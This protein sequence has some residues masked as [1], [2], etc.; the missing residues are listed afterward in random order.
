MKNVRIQRFFPLISVNRISK[1][2]YHLIITFLLF[3]FH[4]AQGDQITEIRIGALTENSS[5]IGK[6]QATALEIAVGNFNNSRN[7]KFSL[8]FQDPGRE[9]L[10]AASAAEDLII[11]E[12]VKV[13]IVGMDSWAKAALVADIGTRAQIP[14]L[15]FAAPAIRP[16]LAATRWPFLIKMASNGAEQI[17]CISAL[18][19]AYNWRRVV[20][21]YED[22]SYGGDSGN[23][24]ALLSEN[25]QKV[26]SQIE[27]SLVLP[28]FSSLPNPKVFLKKKLNKLREEIQSRVFILLKL[29]SPMTIHLFGEAKEL[30]LVGTN[31]AWILSETITS[32]LDSFNDSVISSMQGAL[33]IKANYSEETPSYLKFDDQFREV[34]KSKYPEEDEFKPGI[35][36][37]RAYDS[38]NAIELA[39]KKM[40]SSHS[41]HKVRNILLSTNFNGLS[42]KIRFKDLNRTQSLRI[43]NVGRNGKRYEEIDEF[44][45]P[46][47]GF[48]KTPSPSGGANDVKANL[49]A[50]TVNWPGNST[51]DPKGWAM[52]T[53]QKP[54]KIGVPKRTS[55]EEFVEFD[56]GKIP[57]GFCIDL[58][59]EVLRNLDYN[60]PYE[61]FPHDGPYDD[62]LSKVS[63]KTYDAAV[64][65]I[66]ILAE[67]MELVEFTQAYVESGLSMVAPV[68]SYPEWMFTKPFTRTM[69][70]ATGILFIYTMI[71]VW[72]L[73]HCSNNK[74]FIGKNQIRTALWFTF[75]SLFFAHRDEQIKSNFTRVV[76]AFWLFVVFIIT[77][78]YTASLASLL[79]VKGLESNLDIK[80]VLEKGS[81]VG[82]DNDSFIEDYLKNVLGFKTKQIYI[83]NGSESSYIDEFNKGSIDAA[84]LEVPY[85]KVF[86][87]KYC[88]GYASIK[89]TYRFGGFGFAFQ[90]GSPIAADFSKSILRLSEK[91]NLAA[92]EK[93]WFST[94]D[95]CSA[96][97]TKIERLKF[98]SFWG[99]YAISAGASALCVILF[100]LSRIRQETHQPSNG[101]VQSG[102]NS[103]KTVQLAN[104]RNSRGASTS[105][106][107]SRSPGLYRR[108]TSK[109]NSSTHSDTHHDQPEPSPPTDQIG[110]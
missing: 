39:M 100:L 110:V 15:S 41:S 87:N 35:H 95:K 107:S 25:L 34:F 56:S 109:L 96:A 30:E 78:S 45:L 12:K 46:N 14:I 60:L 29:S 72:I 92:L 90:K 62:L 24:A 73:E 76:V 43:V 16:P 2:S 69:W 53:A 37:L 3:L 97:N 6:E 48:S 83:L 33:G 27:Y 102:T 23:L 20:A 61:F 42:G 13:I 54:L 1:Y 11:K 58:F 89:P 105:P 28:P 5:R 88:D 49:S 66:T 106:T 75:S 55:F 44:W 31:T 99:I 21:I 98:R 10:E 40:G 50:G 101:N 103:N 81:I 19:Q 9:P 71:I 108:S 91:E 8:H 63:N 68:K 70:V 93:K 32:Y 52:P 65:D 86:L 17:R 38:I 64:G 84:I 80:S 47:F 94:S 51:K 57:T 79:T 77:A 7:H 85:E 26:G 22:D 67:R 59:H 74:K 18:I 36:A 104:N 4:G 82:C